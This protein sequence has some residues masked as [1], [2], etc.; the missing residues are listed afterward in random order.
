MENE[1]EL[2]PTVNAVPEENTAAAEEP[3]PVQLL[4]NQPVGRDLQRL[5]HEPR[6]DC[7]PQ[8]PVL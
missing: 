6:C 2:N 4:F 5:R 7:T 1:N 8:H 3:A